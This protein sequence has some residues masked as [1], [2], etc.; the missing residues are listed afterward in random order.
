VGRIVGESAFGGTWTHELTESGGATTHAITEDG[1][2]YN[3][4]F[5]FLARFVIGHTG[6]MEKYQRDLGRKFG[7]PVQ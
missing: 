7:E 5:R 6:T 1:E 4:I 3:P 2:I